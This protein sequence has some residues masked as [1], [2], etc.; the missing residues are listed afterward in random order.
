MK[1]CFFISL[2]AFISF[3]ANGFSFPIYDLSTEKGNKKA[4]AHF[5]ARIE[6]KY[7]LEFLGISSQYLFGA[8]DII[9]GLSFMDKRNMK[10]DESRELI[11]LLI[12]DYW[13]EL[14]TNKVYQ[15]DLTYFSNYFN[16]TPKKK[17]TPER[18]GIQVAFWDENVDRPLYPYVARIQVADGKI[19]YFYADPITQALQEPIVEELDKIVSLTQVKE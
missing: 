16:F 5:A 17:L 14:A 4:R 1:R 12:N 13:K 3:I 2:L 11:K 10:I 18:M 8:K 19:R 15:D 7:H 6:N 9:F